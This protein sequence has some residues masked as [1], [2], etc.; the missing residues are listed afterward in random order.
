MESGER[1]R[2]E[3]KR[4]KLI[5]EIG[6][7]GQPA[8]KLGDRRIKKNEHY[9]TVNKDMKREME[10]GREVSVHEYEK[11]HFDRKNFSPIVADGTQ[12]LFPDGSVDEMIFNNVFG[13]GNSRYPRFYLQEAAR[14]LRKDGTIII[15]ETLT[16]ES[17]LLVKWDN[18]NHI[19]SINPDYY[20]Q[21]GLKVKRLTTDLDKIKLTYNTHGIRKAKNLCPAFQLILKKI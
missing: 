5:I 6:S 10:R 17:S 21:F 3:V 4:Q 8:F 18:E 20:E 16:P 15:A 13:D 9:V 19:L 1:S 2:P 11:K 12:L 7:S 14:V